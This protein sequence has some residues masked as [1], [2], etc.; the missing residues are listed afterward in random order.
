MPIERDGC[1]GDAAN[2]DL[3]FAADIGEIGPIGEHEAKSDQ[4]KGHAARALRALEG[5]MRALGLSGIALHV[6]G[7]N[8]AAHAL[9]VQLGYL[10]TN[11]NMFKA[12]GA[13]GS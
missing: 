11:I 13:A 9:Y 5:E 2:G 3:P 8:A 4:R 7:Q 1:R 12:I 6:F 10:P